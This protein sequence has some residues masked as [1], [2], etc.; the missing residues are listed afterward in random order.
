VTTSSLGNDGRPTDVQATA[1]A[2][3]D[4]SHT[5]S[6]DP[7]AD[8][9]A[10]DAV[11]TKKLKFGFLLKKMNIGEVVEPSRRTF[12]DELSDYVSS[13]SVKP[14]DV[15]AAASIDP[16][17]FWLQN[18]GNRYPTLGQLSLDVISAPAS[19]AYAERVFSYCGVLTAGR[20]NRTAINLHRRAFLCL[21]SKL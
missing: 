8:A 4:A 20:S 1:V 19:E 10:A 13:L 9:A 7:G 16:K 11:P 18:I 21:N 3:R 6:T 17:N 15:A 14:R 12:A 5:D 2:T